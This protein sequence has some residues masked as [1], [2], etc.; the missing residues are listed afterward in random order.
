MKILF[1]YTETK[2]EKILEEYFISIKNISKCTSIQI[3][4]IFMNHCVAIGA[5]LTK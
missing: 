1:I 4:I 2:M 3:H 5:F